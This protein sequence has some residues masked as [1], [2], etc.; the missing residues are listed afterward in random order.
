MKIHKASLTEKVIYFLLEQK[1]RFQN[2]GRAPSGRDD[3][4]GNLLV[5]FPDIDRQFF[6]SFIIL[7]INFSQL[8]GKQ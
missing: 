2:I 4:K 3:M 1:L 6:P 7:R 8:Y 5:S